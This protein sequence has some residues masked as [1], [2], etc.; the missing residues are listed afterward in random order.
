M[1]RSGYVLAPSYLYDSRFLLNVL[2]PLTSE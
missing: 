1:T 2:S